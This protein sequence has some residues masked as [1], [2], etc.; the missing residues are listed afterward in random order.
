MFTKKE[1][2]WIIVA[3]LIMGLA[4]SFYLENDKVKLATDPYLYLISFIIVF[5]PVLIKQLASKHFSI[6]IEHQVWSFQR[7]WIYERSYFK[8]PIPIGLLLPVILSFLS[9][10]FIKPLAILE[11]RSKNIKT[12]VLKKRG[13]FRYTQINESDLAF[14]SA[15]GFWSLI[16]LSLIALVFNIPL[17]GRYA[18]IYGIWNMLPLGHLDGSKLFFGSFFNWCLLAV[19]FIL[20]LSMVI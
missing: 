11:F 19:T 2:I 14:V 3:T 18:I 16:G 17:L 4:I 12:R 6:E 10:G 15:I 8:K 5:V 13:E 9:L 20:S 1:I 7:F